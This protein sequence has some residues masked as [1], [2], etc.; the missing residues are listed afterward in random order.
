MQKVIDKYAGENM[1]LRTRIQ[2]LEDKQSRIE[3]I[4]D[5]I[6][7]VMKTEKRN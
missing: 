3:K 7:E 2:I 1:A 5:S 4:V 6:S